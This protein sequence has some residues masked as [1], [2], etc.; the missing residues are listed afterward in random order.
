MNVLDTFR[1]DEKIAMVTGAGRGIGRTC[2][3]ALAE[4]GADVACIDLNGESATETA[5]MIQRLDRRS[6]GLACDVTDSHAVDRAVARVIDELGS[7]DIAFNNAGICNHAPTEEMTDEQWLSVIDVNLNAVFYC[8]RAAGRAMLRQGRDGRIINTASM[9]GQIVNHPQLQSGYNASKA[10]VIQ[11]TR[12]LAAE[13]APK[14][15]TVNSISPG[16]TGTEMTLAVKEYHDDWRRDTPMGRLAEP[17]EI[18]GA[19]VFLA[20]PAASFITGHDLV[21]DGGF[22]CW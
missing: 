8:S 9:S 3:L 22:T 2:A 21:I 11:L 7:L 17:T 16:Y 20:S 18:C 14:G 6:I 19:V 12:S 15:I 10:G 4:A 5:E 13:W 1:L